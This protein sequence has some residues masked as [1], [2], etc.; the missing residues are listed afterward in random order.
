MRPPSRLEPLPFAVF[1]MSWYGDPSSGKSV[2]AY[3]GGGGSARTGVGNSIIIVEDDE[4]RRSISTGE[5]LG[6]DVALYR[7]PVSGEMHVC[8]VL[9]K[10]WE[11]RRYKFATGVHDA[12]IKVGEACS[13]IAVN[14]MAD[15]VAVGCDNG[16]VKVY[17]MS[18]DEFSEE[19]LIHKHGATHKKAV[20]QIAFSLR[21]NRMITSAKDGTACIYQDGRP[22]TAF[23]CSVQDDTAPKPKIAPTVMVRGCAFLDIE[24]RVAVTVASAKRGKA[25]VARWEQQGQN[26]PFSCTDR[27]P[28]SPCPVSSMCLSQDAALLALGGADGS[29]IV[30][31]VEK[32]T[33][34]KRFAEVHEFPVL[35]IAARPFPV[36]LR[37]EEDGVRIDARSA[38]GDG[39]MGCLTRQRR[40]PRTSGG[41]SGVGSAGK[42]IVN[43]MDVVNRLLLLCLVAYLASPVVHEARQK[44]GRADSRKGASW[45]ICLK[46]DVLIAPSTRPGISSPPY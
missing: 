28:C 27:T 1:G 10:V 45:L 20:T 15:T 26:G 4:P 16:A 40:A 9:D 41:S 31:D 43:F 36:E 18:D 34:A 7:N 46:N 32:W 44:C 13:K 35:C 11:I 24:G 14:A 22:I 5:F 30:W 25:F 38:S 23:K 33:Q 19:L 29:I 39:K 12:T 6:L 2:I 21:Q 3:C 42:S 8:C 37:G 17:R